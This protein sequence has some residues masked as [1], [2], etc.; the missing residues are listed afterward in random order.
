M[1]SQQGLSTNGL[2]MPTDFPRAPYEKIHATLAAK[3]DSQGIYYREHAGA[4][5]A[6]SYRFLAATHYSEDFTSTIIKHKG[7]AST[8]VRYQQ[9]RALFGFFTNALSALEAAFYGIYA[10]GGLVKPG[11]FP[12][13]SAKEQ[14]AVN[15]ASTR[16]IYDKVFPSDPI[17]SVFDRVL[18]DGA[19][20]ELK[21][22]R[23]ILAHRSAPGRQIYLQ[24]GNSEPIPEEWK[25]LNIPLDDK[26]TAIRRAALAQ[27]LAELLQGAQVFA[28]ARF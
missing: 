10:I 8:E 7:S 3:A 13:T 2:V 24:L 14:Q 23:N 5:N 12:F 18:K 6:V 1:K 15:P 25:L 19:Y 20:Q 16:T 11:C 9:E 28:D 27:L 21:Q 4:W 17:I 22:I 26:L